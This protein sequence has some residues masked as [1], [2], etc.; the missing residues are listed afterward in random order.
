[1]NA[2]TRVRVS[3]IRAVNTQDSSLRLK[4]KK[5]RSQVYLRVCTGILSMILYVPS[6]RLNIINR[7]NKNPLKTLP[8]LRS[9]AAQMAIKNSSA[10]EIGGEEVSGKQFQMNNDYKSKV[11]Q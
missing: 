5:Q 10:R 2:N 1:M 4:K 6:K 9:Y 11:R 3:F 8:I 7:C